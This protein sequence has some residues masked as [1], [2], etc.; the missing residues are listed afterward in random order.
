MPSEFFQ[1]RIESLGITEDLNKV[2]LHYYDAGLRE[3]S[4]KEYPIF[5]DGLDGIDIVVYSI[6]RLLINYAKEGSRW[7]NKEYVITRLKD[8][9]QTKSGGLMKYRLPKGQGTFPFFHPWLLDCFDKKTPIDTL[10]LTEGYFK[11]FK[12]C[13]HGIPVVGLT[14]ITHI[15]DKEKG[16]LHPDILALMSTCKVKRVVWLTDG[17]CLN[18]TTKELEDGVDLYRRPHGFFNSVVTFRQVLADHEVDLYFMHIN[19][20]ELGQKTGNGFTPGPKGLDDL[21]VERPDEIPAI[22]DDILS[23]SKPGQYFTKFN[24]TY[25]GQEQKV[26]KHFR[27]KDVNDF[28]AFHVEFRPDLT[29][30]EFRFNGNLYKY[31]SQEGACKLLVPTDARNYFRVGDAYY[32]FVNIPNKYGQLQRAFHGRQKGTITDDHGKNFFKHIAKYKAFCNVPDHTNYQQVIHSCFNLYAPFDHEPEADECTPDDFPNILSFLSHIFGTGKVMYK[33][34]KTQAAMEVDKLDLGLDYLQLLFQQPTHILPILCLV[35]KENETGKSTMAKFLKY[36]FTQNCAIVGNADLANDFNSSWA[37]KLLIICDEAKIEKHIVVEKVKS[38]STAD[39]IMINA[40]G[41]DQVELDFFGKFIFLTNNEENFIYASEEDLR[42]WVIKVPKLKSKNPGFEQSLQDEV[43]AFLSYLSRRKMAT[44][45]LTRMWFDPEL[46]KTDALRKVI[47]HS[48]PTIEKDLRQYFRE[49]FLDFG[50][51]EIMMTLSDIH[52]EVLNKKFEMNYL[53]QVLKERLKV[54]LYHEFTYAGKDY[55]TLQLA[56]AAAIE[57]GE[58]ELEMIRKIERVYK[59]KRHTYPRWEKKGYES[60]Q[61]TTDRVDIKANGR[62]YVFYRKDFVT[63]EDEKAIRY[64]PST[65]FRN[66][67]EPGTAGAG[68]AVAD[69]DRGWIQGEIM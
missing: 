1:Q 65:Q 50:V 8:P 20:I 68:E 40:K 49:A 63:P 11:A 33:H 24:V 39:K 6:D 30:I 7:K 55:L 56:E 22:V 29:N 9:I 69:F 23:V 26:L 48:Q 66:A 2:E 19:S 14:S 58:N 31:D 53:T 60:G 64:D 5:R 43:P 36:L 38:L 42:Y 34:M 12:G 62:P 10:Y 57:A 46:L 61:P 13:M 41:K 21:L 28:F 18:I 3:N 27:L 15:R 67:M 59:I 37:S 52:R 4:V 25:N 32:E 44:E 16:T 45:R 47:A 17:D 51:Q 54:D 35:S